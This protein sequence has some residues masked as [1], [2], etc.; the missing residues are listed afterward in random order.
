MRLIVSGIRP[1]IRKP[2]PQIQLDIPNCNSKNPAVKRA[3]LPLALLAILVIAFRLLGASFAEK[4]P[5]FQP[6]MALV[7]CSF[8]FLKGAQ[9]WILPLAAWIINRVGGYLFGAD[10]T[11]EELVRTLG[12]ASVWNAVGVLGIL[13]SFI[14][15][16][17]CLLAPIMLAAAVALVIAWFV[18]AKTALDLE[19][20]RAIFTVLLGWIVWLVIMIMTNVILNWLGLGSGAL[21][22]I[23]GF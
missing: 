19:W 15:A 6:L 9:R 7:L 11:F 23:I 17:N 2:G 20:P 13:A 21:G 3:F 22:G 5:N 10:V 16:L 14:G 1:K 12:L 18:A 4:L 8:V